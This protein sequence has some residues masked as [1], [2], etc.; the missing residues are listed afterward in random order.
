MSTDITRGPKICPLC[1]ADNSPN[2]AGCW[3][4]FKPLSGAV[5]TTTTPAPGEVRLSAPP[6]MQP[7]AVPGSGWR[8]VG[9]VV[10]VVILAILA[11]GVTLLQVCASTLHF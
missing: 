5:Q 1:G 6:L 4:C 3:L 10:G 9:C 8:T 7:T 2:A 11:A